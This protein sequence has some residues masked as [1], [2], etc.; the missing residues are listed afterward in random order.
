[1]AV[2]IKMPPPGYEELNAEQKLEY[3]DRLYEL[4][5]SEDVKPSSAWQ[6]RILDQRLAA[7]G[8]EPS[9][10][11]PWEESMARV[12]AGLQKHRS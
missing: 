11:R 4:V 9:A 3:I 6:G 5:G 10:A 12:R 1:M 2:S 7:F 8:K